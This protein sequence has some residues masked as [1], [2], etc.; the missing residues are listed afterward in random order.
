MTTSY[1]ASTE[2]TQRLDIG[3]GLG[4]GL[5][6]HANNDSKNDIQQGNPA[7]DVRDDVDSAM[8]SSKFSASHELRPSDRA[9]GE[10]L[11]LARHPP[12]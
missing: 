9:P 12:I 1:A 3:V 5:G 4:L 7:L 8:A 11:R 2:W 6:L 10:S